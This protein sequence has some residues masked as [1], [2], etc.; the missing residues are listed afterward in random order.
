MR[1]FGVAA[2]ADRKE[3]RRPGKLPAVKR[4]PV[5]TRP[6]HGSRSSPRS[7]SSK[8]DLRW[9]AGLPGALAP[10]GF[11]L[12]RKWFR[13]EAPLLTTFNAAISLLA[14][15]LA[16]P[17]TVKGARI[18]SALDI[19]S[20]AIVVLDTAADYLAPA[21]LLAG[22]LAALRARAI[23]RNSGSAKLRWTIASGLLL[24][25]GAWLA[26]ASIYAHMVPSLLTPALSLA[27]GP[28][29]ADI[30]FLNDIAVLFFK[31]AL[32][33]LVGLLLAAKQ[34][35]TSFS[36]GPV[37]AQKYL[38]LAGV[39]ASICIVAIG[40][41][42][43]YRHYRAGDDGAWSVSSLGAEVAKYDSHAYAS[44]FAPGVRCHVSDSFGTRT[45]PFDPHHFEF[46]PGVDMAVAEGTPVRAM[47]TGRVVFAGEDGE[48]GNAVVVQP[49]DG[50]SHPPTL[51]AGHMERL[52]VKAGDMTHQGDVI[53]AAGST[54]RSTG[55]HLHVQLCPSGHV[56]RGGGF[57]CGT[58][59]NP[60][61]TWQMLFAIARASCTLGPVV[62]EAS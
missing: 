9:I 30:A 27:G 55:P 26:L 32:A 4:Q 57:N 58:P 23:R 59:A 20:A 7:K 50:T 3:F 15:M 54:G 37:R 24:V 52:F 40:T 43:G 48:F 22:A 29:T 61:E 28:L 45:D 25:S 62:P 33:F 42:I 19:L 12:L 5:S 47:A 2:R 34:M 17:M 39:A 49:N 44:P 1:L 6:G 60:Y 11:G 46:H 10:K 18:A 13:S 35:K 8:V 21:L 41:A 38:A 31:P 16:L 36:K 56:G 53:G 51:L 14:L